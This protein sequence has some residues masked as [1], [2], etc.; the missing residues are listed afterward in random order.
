MSLLV[1][2]FDRRHLLQVMR[3]TYLSQMT[4]RFS[5]INQEDNLPTFHVQPLRIRHKYDRDLVALETGV[6][7]VQRL[8]SK[9]RRRPRV[10]LVVYAVPDRPHRPCRLSDVPMDLGH[11]TPRSPIFLEYQRHPES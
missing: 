1:R 3:R 8:R 9:A 4:W 5:P 10:Q 2:V 7:L 11:Q 6:L